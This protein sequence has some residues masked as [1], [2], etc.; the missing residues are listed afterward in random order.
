[1]DARTCLTCFSE[2]VL[3]ICLNISLIDLSSIGGFFSKYFLNQALAIKN[4]AT[5]PITTVPTAIAITQYHSIICD[6]SFRK[7]IFILLYF[8]INYNVNVYLIL[9]SFYCLYLF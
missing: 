2:G 5:A 6:N 8:I 9:I 1:M 7:Y 3:P 4:P